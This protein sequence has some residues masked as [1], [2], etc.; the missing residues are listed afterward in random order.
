MEGNEAEFSVF[1]ALELHK[2]AVLTEVLGGGEED[3]LGLETL[4]HSSLL[5]D[6]RLIIM[7]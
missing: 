3:I 4:V 5:R 7:N 6:S 2:G 1:L